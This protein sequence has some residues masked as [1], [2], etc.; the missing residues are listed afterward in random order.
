MKYL[1]FLNAKIAFLLLSMAIC[2]TTSHDVYGNQ[3]NFRA[4][5]D[6]L[7]NIA[8]VWMEADSSNIF[9][10]GLYGT[11]LSD[12]P[13]PLTNTSQYIVGRP[14]LAVSASSTPVATAAAVYSAYDLNTLQTVILGS[15][16]TSAGWNTTPFIF[17][18]DDGSEYPNSDYTICISSDSNQILVNW[19]SYMVD[20]QTMI[21]RY[22]Q[23]TDGGKTFLL[24]D[25]PTSP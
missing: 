13:T 10:N 2:M 25:I 8:A 14:V 23:S 9:I 20:T 11:S 5:F 24:Q 21:F 17:S 22:A 16:A 7:N 12:Q 19:T 6:G 15:V 4:G 3:Y 1:Q 18:L